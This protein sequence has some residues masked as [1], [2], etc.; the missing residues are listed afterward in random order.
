MLYE[1]LK[2][3]MMV[4]QQSSVR[5]SRHANVGIFSIIPSFLVSVLFIDPYFVL[6]LYTSVS[7]DL[8][9]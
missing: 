8:Y 5:K 3:E 2:Q 9:M 4:L 6:K 1:L 7:V